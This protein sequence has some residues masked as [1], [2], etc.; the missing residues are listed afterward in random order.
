MS[1]RAQLADPASPDIAHG[2]SLQRIGGDAAIIVG[3]SLLANAFNYLFH[4]LISRR[5]GPDAYGTL[6][7]SRGT[8]FRV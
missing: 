1:E 4:F 5:L 3:G 6:A 8:L 2:F 7:T